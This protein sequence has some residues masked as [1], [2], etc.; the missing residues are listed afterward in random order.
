MANIII[1]N[2]QLPLILGVSFIIIGS[3]HLIATIRGM[4]INNSLT[5]FIKVLLSL[6][7]LYSSIKLATMGYTFMEIL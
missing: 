1:T 5:N 2:D 4:N 6:T 3:Y 7:L